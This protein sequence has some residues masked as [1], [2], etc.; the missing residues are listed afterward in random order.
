MFIILPIRRVL[1]NLPSAWLAICI[2]NRHG[3]L[4]KKASSIWST[5][6]L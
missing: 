5:R 4:Q 3:S 6:Q 2:R 1:S